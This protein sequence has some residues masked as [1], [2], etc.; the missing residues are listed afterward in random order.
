MKGS[1]YTIMELKTL[2][3]IQSVIDGT[4][5]GKEAAI[6]LNISERQV[7]RKVKSVRENG[8]IGIKHKNQ[9]HK[10][11]HTIPVHM[12]NKIIQLKLSPLYRDTNFT[13]FQEL[14]QEN[15]NIS[16][17]YTSV[18]R[19]LSSAGIK[20]KKKHKERKIHRRRKCFYS[21]KYIPL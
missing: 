16:I 8:P 21:R 7:W 2:N 13:H 9:F 3:I 10:P 20:S 1:Y 12:K 19:I 14:L 18:Y 4:R 17:S 15:E 5:T 11:H 6:T